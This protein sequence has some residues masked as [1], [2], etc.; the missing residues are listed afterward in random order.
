M[1]NLPEPVFL[2]IISLVQRPKDVVSFAMSCKLYSGIVARYMPQILASYTQGIQGHLGVVYDAVC[3]GYAPWIE[4]AANAVCGIYWKP[5]G[6]PRLL[7]S[8][9]RSSVTATR[10][11]MMIDDMNAACQCALRYKYRLPLLLHQ[12]LWLASR[13][14]KRR[15][16]PQRDDHT[17]EDDTT[18]MF[19]SLYELILL[20][21][22]DDCL[23]LGDSDIGASDESLEY[24]R[25]HL[26][27]SRFI[28]PHMF[29]RKSDSARVNRWAAECVRYLNKQTASEN[30]YRSGPHAK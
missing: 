1:E 24:I 19:L 14:Y 15:L 20:S 21:I 16:N 13:A 29:N 28:T 25:C 11:N 23:R 8:L 30:P 26:V 18:L 5:N 6:K 4:A 3:D 7:G 17:P 12:F 2:Y 22:V 10:E 27:A 9:Y